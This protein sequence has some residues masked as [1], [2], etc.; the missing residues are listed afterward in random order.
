MICLAAKYKEYDNVRNILS[1]KIPQPKPEIKGQTPKKRKHEGRQL[2]S[3][4]RQQ[5]DRTPARA[6]LQPWEVDPYE[7][8]SVIRNLFASEKKTA[9]GPTPQK[10]GQVLGL[11]DLLQDSGSEPT[12]SKKENLKPPGT[13]ITQATPNKSR[14]IDT[15]KHSRTPA[16]ASKR[17]LLDA[18]A[19]PSKNKLLN[20]PG[21]KTPSSVS[22]L[23]FSTPSFLRRDSQRVRQ[24]PAVNENEDGLALS[25]EVIRVPRK[26]LVRGLSSMLA[27]L[28]KMEE[29]AADD[30]LEALH[31]MENEMAGISNKPAAKTQT[32]ANPKPKPKSIQEEAE[33]EDQDALNALHEMENEAGNNTT[34]TAKSNPKP[35]PEILVEDSQTGL[36][37]GFD[38]IAAYDSAPED[39]KDRDGQPLKVYK[40]KGQKRTTRRVNMKPVRSKPAA[41]PIPADEESDDEL[42]G[43]KL[44]AETQLVEGDD[45]SG[46]ADARNFD[47]DSQSEYT[48]SEGG[49]RY[50]RPDQSKKRK[51]MGK[52]GKIKTAARKVTALANQNFKRLKLRNSGAKG[53]VAHNSRFRRK[54]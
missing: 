2:E 31:E 16:S 8:P 36:L 26:P 39:P 37:G 7:S 49:T 23:H 17:Y 18:F 21:G 9:L 42:A 10:D 35:Q 30:D 47:S 14:Q 50:R 40:K 1:G 38:D 54:K 24:L 19:T 15:M 51:V 29:E 32:K 48:A 28:R 34:V 11:F 22:K 5:I 43:D 45:M 27:S 4:K 33:D 53:G 12:P 6:S 20:T 44:V 46:F 25:P 3:S 41:N 52:D 13:H